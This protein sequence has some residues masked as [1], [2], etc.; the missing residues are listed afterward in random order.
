MASDESPRCPA[1]TLD[2]ASPMR[3]N[4]DQIG[5]PLAA[6]SMILSDVTYLDGG[7]HLDLAA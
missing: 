3:T 5:T 1:E 2:T 7:I 6:E 4:N